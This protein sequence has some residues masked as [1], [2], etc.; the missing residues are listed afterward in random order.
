M[1]SRDYYKISFAL[2]LYDLLNDSKKNSKHYSEIFLILKL[3]EDNP[4]FI[5]ILDDLFL[6]FDKKSK[7]LKEAFANVNELILNAMLILVNSSHFAMIIPILKKLKELFQQ[8][9]KIKEGLVYSTTKLNDKTIK[10]L[11]QKVGND[12]QVKVRLENYIDKE[13]IG[14]FKIVVDDYVVEDSVKSHLKNLKEQLINKTEGE[15]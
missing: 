3:L 13:L 1:K 12:L 7:L 8:D 2:A 4:E 9:L 14:G 5:E 11:E 6:S 10:L 15:L